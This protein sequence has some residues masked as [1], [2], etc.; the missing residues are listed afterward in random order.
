ME[1]VLRLNKMKTKFWIII[2]IAVLVVGVVLTFTIGSFGG[3]KLDQKYQY[4]FWQKNVES[5]NNYLRVLFSRSDDYGKTFSEPVD[6]SMTNLN[7]H[8]PKMIIMN[9]DVILVWR[10]E[11]PNNLP[12]LSFAKSADFGKTFEKKRLFYGARPDIKYYDKILYLTYVNMTDP[13]IPQIWY[14][15][16]NDGGETFAEPKLIFQVDWVLSVFE[17]RPTP[18]LE[19]DADKVVITW[20]MENKD[21]QYTAWKA[22]DYG[23]DDSFEI[24]SSATQRD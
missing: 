19:V 24:T 13:F 18:T 2:G 10:D 12:D 17:D 1:H 14:S 15:K 9:N 22:I 6:M 4:K 11:A 5:E 7:A 8:E 21:N 20:K 16:S 23:K 3:T